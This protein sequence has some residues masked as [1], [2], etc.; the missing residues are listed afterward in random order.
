VRSNILADMSDAVAI[1]VRGA[2]KGFR[3]PA[4]RSKDRSRPGPRNPFN[5]R[6]RELDVLRD[7]SFD[8]HKGEFFGI[9][10]RN[11]S[12]KSTLLK[13]LASVYKA[14]AGTIRI[15]GRLAPFLELGVGFNPQLPAYENI[16]MNGVMMGLPPD[17][18]RARYEEIM[19]FAGLREYPDL[20]VR[21]YSV[22]M[23]ARLGFAIMTHV[24]A[25]ILL[26][27]EVLAVGDAEFQEKCIGV[28]DRMHAEGRTIVLVTHSMAT[29]NTYCERAM[30]INEGTIDMLGDPASVANRY[31]EV[32]AQ[33]FVGKGRDGVGVVERYLAAL[34]NPP[35]RIV[36]AW[37]GDHDGRRIRELDRGVPIELHADIEILR[38]VPGP[39]FGFKILDKMGTPL[40]V[41]DEVE[42]DADEQPRPGDRFHVTATVENRIRGGHYILV[43]TMSERGPSGSAELAGPSTAIS[44]EVRGPED[45]GMLSLEY[46]TSSAR[47]SKENEEVRA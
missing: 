46:A 35:A 5:R 41:S 22:G 7:I 33:V 29:V 11:G 24:D 36:D 9:V 26:I 3:I 6:G 27:D 43:A 21:N 25:D 47:V 42:L 19:D 32:N 44:F 28:F 40:F 10:G 13:L 20:Q 31:M 38:D 45:R 2:C 30:L 34:S 39:A 16:I 14:D 12:G 23:K 18:A 37:L 17:E 4:P 15:A 1:E 8:V